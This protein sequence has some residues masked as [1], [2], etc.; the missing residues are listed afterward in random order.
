MYCKPWILRFLY[1]TE[2]NERA[3]INDN[4]KAFSEENFSK[5]KN[6]TISEPVNGTKKYELNYKNFEN[7]SDDEKSFNLGSQSTVEYSYCELKLLDNSKKSILSEDASVKS[8]IK[9][10][11]VP[12]SSI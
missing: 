8:N 5:I 10:R 12:K 3:E 1:R 2:N 4:I 11:Y 9:S 6:E 7:L